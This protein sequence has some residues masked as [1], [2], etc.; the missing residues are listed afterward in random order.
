VIFPPQ[1]KRP[2]GYFQRLPLV[3][4]SKVPLM[5]NFYDCHFL[6]LVNSVPLLF[7]SPLNSPQ[8]FN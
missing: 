1:G 7:F 3:Y 4:D 8:G 2:A 5:G 6:K